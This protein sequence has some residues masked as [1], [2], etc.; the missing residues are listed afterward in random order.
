MK[1]LMIAA[2][3]VCAATL[4]Q[5]ATVTWKSGAT[6]LNDGKTQ[7][8]ATGTP[9]VS[10]TL[11][12]ISATQYAGWLADLATDYDSAV[13][14]I[15]DWSKTQGNLASGTYEPGKIATGN[16]SK[17]KLTLT[18]TRDISTAGKG[19]DAIDLYSAIIY[20]YNDGKDDYYI[21]NV[22]TMHFEANVTDY[23][24][25][26]ANSLGGSASALNDIGWTTAAVPEPTSGLLLLLG[27]AGLALRRRRA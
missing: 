17:G 5:A 25:N 9:T 21:A 8:G 6:L 2:A 19:E 20:T 18:D 10:G 24:D 26:L 7:A 27:V 1:K 22:S 4:S 12:G 11:Y 23:K 13:K 16:F 15:V 3:I 14:S